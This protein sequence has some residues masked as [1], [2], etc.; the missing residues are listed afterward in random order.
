[1]HKYFL[2]VALGISAIPSYAAI[3]TN[4]SPL[5]YLPKGS[6]AG[7]T[8]QIP[9]GD[10]PLAV[11]T[12]QLFPPASTLKLVTALAAKL[13][14]G[15]HFRFKT[16]IERSGNDLIFR[17]SGDPTLTSNDL[18]SLIKQIK[19]AG[20]T[21]IKG[22]IW[23]NNSAFTGYERAVGWPW[24]ILGVCYSAPASAITL[25]NN[26]VQASIYTQNNGKT[27]VYVP[28]HQPIRVETEAITVTR[29]GQKSRQ[30]DLDLITF[31]GNEYLL[32]GCLVEREKPL[33]LKFA[34]QETHAYTSAVL[35]RLLK[36]H[37]IKFNGDIELS[38]RHEGKVL[39]THSSV[40]LP[41]LLDNML[42][43][44]N[45]LIADNL[46]K[47]IGARFSHH[48]GSFKNGTEA[49]K[50]I[51]LTKAGIDLSRA[52]I[53]DGSGLSRNNRVTASDMIKVLEYIWK[54][55]NQLKLLA[56][57][58]KAGESGTLRYRKSM[59][60]EPI[61]GH[62]LAKSGS[63]YGSYN[64]AGYSVDDSGSP[65]ALFVQFVTDY[66]PKKKDGAKNTTPPI[67]QFEKAFYKDVITQK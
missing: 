3:A 47:S 46:T 19:K 65:K 40:A 6:R 17:F 21:H 57:L 48:P 33:P 10:T 18:E 12:D 4:Y 50:Q 61:K 25:D 66:Y 14:L 67:F 35:R 13:E 59:R 1:M 7:L 36:K 60:N 41:V 11:N 28:E 34:V 27:R 51:L 45:N 31:D 64:M 32:S 26:C 53:A 22:D 29:E 43:H 54:H 20:I 56:M 44:S 63:L 58:P 5:D 9:G 52:Q 23:L 16:R 24:D 15:D 38:H 55:D 30:C 62:L 2:L 8:I 39:A 42:K 49:I 37:G